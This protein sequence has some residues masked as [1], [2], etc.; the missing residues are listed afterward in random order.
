MWNKI[1]YLVLSIVGRAISHRKETY[2]HPNKRDTGSIGTILNRFSHKNRETFLP[3]LL[4]FLF[5]M[6]IGCA[7]PAM[8]LPPEQVMANRII[9]QNKSGLQNQLLNQMSQSKL[10]DYTDYAVGPEDLLEVTFLGQENLK[11]EVRVN[12]EGEIA[13]PLI[14][15]VKV[16]ELS[17]N[18]IETRLVQLYREQRY[19]KNPQITVFVKE[20][21]HKKVMVTGAVQTPGAYDIIGPRTLLEMLGKAGGLKETASNKVHIVRSQSYAEV[22]KANNRQEAKS[23]QPYPPGSK[24]TEVDLNQLM[25]EGGTA[26]NVPIKNGDVIHVPFANNAFVMGAVNRPGN[27][28]VKDNLTVTQALAMAGGINPTYGS[29]NISILRVEANG[30]R[31]K[32]PVDIGQ[33][34]AGDSIDVPLKE[35]DVVFV[36]ES[37][38]KKFLYDFKVLNPIPASAP[39]FY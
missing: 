22:N 8:V 32:I 21:R 12:G 38:W 15:A 26:L 11:R 6:G 17:P 25:T 39:T 14:G 23:L 5:L 1:A 35:N 3:I 31:I 10:K 4:T 29:N 7:G 9:Q 16:A 13:L 18:K 20:Y 19:I 36:K 30:Q 2:V 24:I 33:V 28:M 37:G 27:V 34:T